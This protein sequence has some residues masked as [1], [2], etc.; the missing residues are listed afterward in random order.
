MAQDFVRHQDTLLQRAGTAAFDPL[1]GAAPV[2]LPSIRT[3]TVRFKNLQAL[4]E[5]IAAKARGERRVT[6]G[7]VGMD[8]HAALEDVFCTLE[9]ADRAFLAPSGAAA[10]TLA[11]LSLLNH[12]DH[13]LIAD[14]VYGPVRFFEQAVL[15]RMGIEA[16]Y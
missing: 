11:M 14:C 10:I 6:Y 13:V 12:G 15:R 2:A 4:D 16:T 9:G 3:S 1:T 7:R 8:T 5:A